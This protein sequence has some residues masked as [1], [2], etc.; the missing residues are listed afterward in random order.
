MLRRLQIQKYNP[1][2]CGVVGVCPMSLSPIRP[3]TK[4]FHTVSLAQSREATGS[5]SIKI[6]QPS[7]AWF[8]APCHDDGRLLGSESGQDPTDEVGSHGGYNGGEGVGTGQSCSYQLLPSPTTPTRRSPSALHDAQGAL[9]T[10]HP[11]SDGYVPASTICSTVTRVRRQAR[12]VGR[13]EDGAWKARH[14]L[15]GGIQNAAGQGCQQPKLK[16]TGYATEGGH[17]LTP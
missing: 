13:G 9:A 8:P 7:S 3:S 16:R 6:K 11:L 12:T 15:T 17:A 1:V 5:E 4:F 14:R 2:H 10:C